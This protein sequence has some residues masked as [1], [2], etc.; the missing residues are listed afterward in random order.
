MFKTCIA[1]IFWV[2]ILASL[3]IFNE[4]KIHTTHQTNQSK[5]KNKRRPNKN[6]NNDDEKKCFGTFEKF[7][8]VP[9]SSNPSTWFN[10][11]RIATNISLWKL[12]IAAIIIDTIE[13]QCKWT[14]NLWV[15]TAHKTHDEIAELS[16]TKTGCEPLNAEYR[17][18]ITFFI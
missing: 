13:C 18:T 4:N 2:L 10:C 17:H 3:L 8:R 15:E 6:Q 5:K 1:R 7:T 16:Q 11:S 9:A 12:A 14:W